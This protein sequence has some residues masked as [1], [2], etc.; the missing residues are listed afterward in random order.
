MAAPVL[1]ACRSKAICGQSYVCG[2]RCCTRHGHTRD[3]ATFAFCFHISVCFTHVGICSILPAV[4]SRTFRVWNSEARASNPSHCLYQPRYTCMCAYI[5]IYIYNMIYIYIYIYTH[6]TYTC[7][8]IYI[9]IYIHMHIDMC[10]HVCL[11]FT[12]SSRRVCPV[13][14]LQV[15]NALYIYIYIIICMIYIYIYIEREREMYYPPCVWRV[16]LQ[17]LKLHLRIAIVR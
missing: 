10:M 5:Y 9:Y 16:L 1:T 17:T 4:S 15:T 14:L 7:M 2:I 8:C 3:R 12:S 13:L 6:D 11:P